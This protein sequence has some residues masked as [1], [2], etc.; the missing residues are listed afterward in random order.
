MSELEKRSRFG[1]YC[2]LSLIGQGGMG[3]VYLA[4]D[5]TLERRVALKVLDHAVVACGDFEQRFRQEARVIASLQHPN[6][7]QIHSL[8]RVGDDLAIDMP[9]IE[10]G[11]LSNAVAHGAMPLS[12]L[13]SVCHD[14]LLALA[15]CHEAGI[16]HRD[17]KPENIL[18]TADGRA[19]LSD[20]GLAKLLADHQRATIRRSSSSGFFMGTP[21]Y[22]PPEFWD[23]ATPTRASDIYSVGMVM[24]E[25]IAGRAP[26]DAETP[27]A[28]VKQI[29]ERPIPSLRTLNPG[30]SAELSDLVDS[31]LK[32]ERCER[33]QDASQTLERLRNVPEMALMT[34]TSVTLPQTRNVT[35]RRRLVPRRMMR[36]PSD[37]R[38][39]K[40]LA[41][42]LSGIC[43]ALV[44]VLA[45][46]LAS[47]HA[48]KTPNEAVP[49][50]A[51]PASPAPVP[52]GRT[53]W[54]FD[55]LN[56]ETQRTWPGHCLIV[57]A[58]S[59]QGWR[60]IAWESSH[61]WQ[62]D[63]APEAE[64]VQNVAG[65]WAE[66]A[67]ATARVFRYGTL[68]GTGHWL[69]TAEQIS[70]S[71]S[72]VGAQDGSSTPMS[73]I[74]NV[75]ERQ[76]TEAD[77]ACRLLGSDYAQALLY[78]ELLPRKALWIAE[79]ERDFL[80]AGTPR[81]VVPHL[82]DSK[83]PALVMDG[84]LDEPAWQFFA[85]PARGNG[86]DG[87]LPCSSGGGR[88]LLLARYDDKAL[89]L[90]FRFSETMAAPRLLVGIMNEFFVPV[91][92]SPRRL[93][94]A[95]R[96][97]VEMQHRIQNGSEEEWSASTTMACS[98][99]ETGWCAE[100]CIPF[101]D[102][103]SDMPQPETRWRLDAFAL[104]TAKGGDHPVAFW[105]DADFKRLELGV[106]VIFG[107]RS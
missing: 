61:V 24:Y 59:T 93:I 12:R 28:L 75:S 83:A 14:V 9:F 44:C 39:G 76:E 82:H 79:A 65:N 72:F 17:I 85:S 73:L 45:F 102:F 20:F 27:L 30:I 34:E 105:G 53:A 90:A 36:S 86:E 97:G 49:T 60:A 50:P 3:V 91:A 29:I 55:T 7:I 41:L 52:A 31:M 33:P 4:E 67:D 103:G 98:D 84:K 54:V 16:V 15:C 26:Y 18:L 66:Y 5:T 13:L 38:R 6:I 51:P 69:R 19:L 71:L 63:I 87:V 23:A 81:L 40:S 104:D 95:G 42:A 70:L 89:Y 58:G 88:S 99:G 11:S 78:N 46:F 25:A 96:N 43:V 77:F 8:E 74:M 62:F 1:K 47:H 35:Q 21:R 10:A 107:E 94:Q 37:I 68:S 64:N 48:E 2:L 106:L 22:A 32:H 92:K 101:S 100:M 56:P 57:R 80:G